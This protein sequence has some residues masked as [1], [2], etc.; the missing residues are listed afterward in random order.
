MLIYN[1]NLRKLNS[2]SLVHL[3]RKGNLLFINV[4]LYL[5][6]NGLQITKGY[7]EEDKRMSLLIEYLN[8][9]FYEYYLYFSVYTRYIRYIRR[10]AISK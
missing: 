9:K 6:D 10:L 3:I 2:F 5:L 7:C 1:R 8:I 4:K